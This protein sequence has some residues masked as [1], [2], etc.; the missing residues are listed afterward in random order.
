MYFYMHC[1]E[2]LI[3]SSILIIFSYN[4]IYADLFIME[5]F[6]TQILVICHSSYIS[7][8]SAQEVKNT[9]DM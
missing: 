3:V 1:K 4:V 5:D 2:S 8:G 9:I 6:R 7:T